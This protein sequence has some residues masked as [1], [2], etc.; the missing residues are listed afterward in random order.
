MNASQPE[1]RAELQPGERRRKRRNAQRTLRGDGIGPLAPRRQARMYGSA[2]IE[3]MP[4]GR[5]SPVARF[6]IPRDVYT[7]KP[8]FTIIQQFIASTARCKSEP[9]GRCYYAAEILSPRQ[10]LPH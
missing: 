9:A 5:V 10:S 3:R 8:A 6:G 4:Y 2:L 1:S 7:L